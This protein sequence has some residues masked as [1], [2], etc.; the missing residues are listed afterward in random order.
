MLNWI[1]SNN[2]DKHLNQTKKIRVNGI[3]FVIKKINAV[4]Y[5]DGSHALKV[6]YE[7]YKNKKVDADAVVSNKKVMEHFSHVLCAGVV[8]PKLS[9]KDND[10]GLFVDKLFVDWNMVTTIYNEIMGFT[11]GKKKMKQLVSQETS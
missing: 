10:D 11:Y 8:S 4:N 5:L 2:L 3:R 9:L 6:T 1:F 7:L